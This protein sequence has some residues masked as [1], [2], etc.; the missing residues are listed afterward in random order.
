MTDASTTLGDLWSR[1]AGEPG[2]LD[3]VTMTGADSVLPVSRGQ[4]RGR[5]DRPWAAVR[6]VSGGEMRVARLPRR[7]FYAVQAGALADGILTDDEVLA[8]AGTSFSFSE[9]VA[10]SPGF[11]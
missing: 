3:R 8:F 5:E 11:P 4:Q 1:A 6:S 10:G 2:A 9:E 7:A